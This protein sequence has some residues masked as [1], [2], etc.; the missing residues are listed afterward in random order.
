M[1]DD[2]ARCQRTLAEGFRSIWEILPYT[3]SAISFAFPGPPTTRTASSETCPTSRVS[4]EAWLRPY[5][6]HVFGI[7][8]FIKQRRQLVRLRR[9]LTGI[10]PEVNDRL[11][12]CGSQRRYHNL[13]GVTLGTGF[14]AGVVIRNELLT[15]D[16]STGG[17]VWC[18]RNHKYPEYIV[19]ESVSI[20][21]VRHV[22]ARESGSAEN[23]SP[24]DIFQIAEGTRNGN[25]EAARAAFAEL[26]QM[27]AEALASALTLIDGLVVIG[28]ACRVPINTSAPPC[29]KV[30][31]AHWACATAAVSPRLQMEIYDLEDEKEF[32]A[33][34]TTPKRLIPVLDTDRTIPYD[35]FKRTGIAL[36]RQGT[37][38]SIALGAYTFAL[39]QLD[40]P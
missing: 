39:R 37:N 32:E 19:E 1:T 11:K 13:I 29:L 24:K 15:G 31:A 3:P 40:R 14:G 22:Y 36:T 33:F 30:C 8:V 28:G 26:G 12:A 2:A 35:A 4:G 7:P 17:D 5:L 9:S 6:E 21:A 16:N 20:R 38:R 27:A 25:P 34:A 23:L 18:Q 10:L